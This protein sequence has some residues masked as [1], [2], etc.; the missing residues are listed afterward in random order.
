MNKKIKRIV[1][2]L[3]AAAC[4]TGAPSALGFSSLAPLTAMADSGEISGEI[5]GYSYRVFK[6]QEE[7]LC[8]YENSGTNGFTAEW[9][10]KY[11]VTV[12]KGISYENQGIKAY[13]VS[14]YEIDYEADITTAGNAYIGIG[15]WFT[16]PLISFNIVEAYGDWMPPGAEGDNIQK[17]STA[18]I[19]G[20]Y[21]QIYKCQHGVRENAYNSYWSVCINKQMELNHSNHV[22]GTV[23]VAEHFKAWSEAGLPLGDLYEIDFQLDAFNSTGSME[24]KRMN[25]YRTISNDYVFGPKG[26]EKAYPKHDPLPVGD[27]GSIITLDMECEDFKAGTEGNCTAAL[28]DEQAYSDDQSMQITAGDSGAFCYEIDPYDLPVSMYYAKKDYL[29]GAKIFQKSGKD[30]SMKVELVEYSDAPQN[31]LRRISLGT[32]KCVSGQWTSITDIPFTINFDPYHKYKLVYTPSSPV[33]FYI[34]DFCISS[35]EPEYTS[36]AKRLR[37]DLNGD[38]VVNSLDIP[39]CRKAILNAMDDN[40]ISVEG[41]V[42]GDLRSNVSDLVLLTRFVLNTIDEIPVSQDEAELIIGD[43]KKTG[44]TGERSFEISGGKVN[45]DSL[46]AIVRKDG[47][48]SAEWNDTKLYRLTSYEFYDGEAAD[49]KCTDCNIRY[50]ADIMSDGDM[51]MHF[52]GNFIHKGNTQE[53]HFVI[54]EFRTEGGQL[55][56]SLQKALDEGKL[57]TATINGKEYYT[58]HNGPVSEPSAIF[59]Y[60]KDAVSPVGK[61]AHTEDVL[62][63]D[64]FLAYWFDDNTDEDILTWAGFELDAFNCSGNADIKE[65]SFCNAPEYHKN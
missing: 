11:D 3:T 42:N 25:T 5:D 55:D 1:S 36:A 8:N 32:R 39:V 58:E 35:G 38:G 22:A 56:E 54:Y 27:D 61:S 53:T 43:A 23:N 4:I 60:R 31:Y 28:T 24:L 50:S 44:E 26:Q 45:D 63:L 48:V 13:R 37:G 17:L 41:D 20:K 33:G 18:F 62:S 14:E 64:D 2:A 9:D 65:L 47:S 12:T 7:S 6:S 52:Y 49:K 46:K 10:A 30:L 59:F 40:M 34:D 16:D 51:D 15:G 21:Y 29:T 57:G 19:D